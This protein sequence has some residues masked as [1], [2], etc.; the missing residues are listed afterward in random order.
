MMVLIFQAVRQELKLSHLKKLMVEKSAE[1]K[2]KEETIIEVKKKVQELKTTLTYVNQKIDNLKKQSSGFEKTDKEVEKSLQAC[3]T[4]K[5]NNIKRN[6]EIAESMTDLKGNY[7]KAK[8]KAEEE[9]QSLKQ[10]VLDRDKA[11]CAFADLTR[12]EARKLC[13]VSEAPK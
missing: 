7:E 8:I 2:Q 10:Q 1:V 5:E 4:E 12:E 3:N 9:I 11:I 6:V 13:G